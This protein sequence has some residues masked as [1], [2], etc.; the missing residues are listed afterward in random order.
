M[1]VLDDCT[2]RWTV[3]TATVEGGGMTE[4]RDKGDTAIGEAKLPPALPTTV[5]VNRSIA[6]GNFVILP[7]DDSKK[8]T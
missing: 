7:I 8:Q 2:S 5:D 4:N 3:K 6:L 1:V